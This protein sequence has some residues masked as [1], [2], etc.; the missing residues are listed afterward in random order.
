MAITAL[1]VLKSLDVIKQAAFAYLT[2]ERLYPN[3][4]YFSD[5][6][7]FGEPS[8]LREAIEFI[9]HNLFERG[10]DKNKIDSLIK[11][12]EKNTPDTEHFTTT[13]VSSALDACAVIFESLNFLIDKK[14]SRIEAIS[15]LSTDT[16]DMYIQ[17]IEAL[18]F[19]KD[20][21]FR[22]KIDNHPLMK[23]ELTIQSG[24]TSFLNNS[25]NIDQG[26]IQTLLNLQENNKKGSLGL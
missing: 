1:N 20:K 26:D 3:Y 17:E 12:I 9:Y 6:Y 13:F 24:I 21:D 14:F 25:K 7:G 8:E 5:N 19:N 22:K 2:C 10:P 16:V 11:K 18:D 23:K 4:V 15:A